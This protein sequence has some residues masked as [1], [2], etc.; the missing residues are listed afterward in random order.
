MLLPPFLPFNIF[1]FFLSLLPFMR[2]CLRV[3]TVTDDVRGASG[4]MRVPFIA[5]PDVITSSGQS[6]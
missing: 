2:F 3:A 6:C 1:S 5:L 4:T